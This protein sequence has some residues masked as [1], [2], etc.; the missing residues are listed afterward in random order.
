MKNKINFLKIFFYI[1]LIILGKV[2]NVDKFGYILL[3]LSVFLDFIFEF[4]IMYIENISFALS[5]IYIKR[6]K[7]LFRFISFEFDLIFIFSFLGLIFDILEKN[8]I[9]L[10]ILILIFTIIIFT[11]YIIK[12]FSKERLIF[13]KA[14]QKDRE[15]VLNLYV[16]GANSLKS[17]LVDQWQGKYY[18]TFKDVDQH[19]LLDLYVLEYKY[20]IVSTA[21]LV[22][23]VDYDYEKIQGKWNTKIPYISIHKVATKSNYKNQA[24]TQ[25]LMYFIEIY[26]KKKNLDLRID[27]HQDNKKMRNFI[28]RCGFKYCGIVYLHNELK[29]LAYDKKIST[30]K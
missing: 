21:C 29:R 26:A 10:L 14:T 23:K 11:I 12:N 7:C 2:F 30:I 22:E 20:D 3:L 4:N 28:L 5:N 25:K 8:L 15:K 17:D 18:P 27:T 19:L 16:D 13:R 9:I 6:I 24:F 1:L